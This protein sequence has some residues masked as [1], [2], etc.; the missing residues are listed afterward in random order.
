[1]RAS[2]AIPDTLVLLLAL[3]GACLAGCG[4][5][6]T[7]RTA[8][9]G[10]ALRL[11]PTTT[12]ALELLSLLADPSEVVAVPEQAD[13]YSVEDFRQGG[14]ETQPRFAKYEAETLLALRPSLVINHRWQSEDTN[15]VLRKAGIPVLSLDSGTDY[16]TVQACIRQLGAALGRE[17]RARAALAE[18]DGR[19]AEL[20]A[21]RPAQ[22]PRML[23]YSND[24]S[25]GW[26]AGTHT[27]VDAVLALCGFDNAAAIAGIE[28]HASCSFEQL[29]SIDPE[30]ILCAVPAEG[31]PGLPTRSILQ[32]TA[33]LA[34]L[35]ARREGRLLELGGA[36]L[37]S[38]S[39]HI[40]TAAER[41][42]R[43]YRQHPAQGAAPR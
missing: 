23:V 34:S 42:L 25:A 24:G 7:R 15:R 40:V 11:V 21:Q 16:A 31:E 3:L 8:P 13:R 30:W 22:R 1:M 17:E 4:P 5:E 33:A 19:V 29:L 2:Q 32:Q 18:L 36:L 41:L 9:A 43:A 20:A 38:D 28:G 14:W 37:S 12:A 10:E 35:S 26:V 27:T 6:P 39:Q